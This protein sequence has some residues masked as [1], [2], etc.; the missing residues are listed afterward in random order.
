MFQHNDYTITRL[1]AAQIQVVGKNRKSHVLFAPKGDTSTPS[2]PC[3]VYG[4]CGHQ[5]AAVAFL[6][7]EVQPQAQPAPKVVQTLEERFAWG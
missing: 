6:T 3:K 2:C 4:T 1:S 5:L 7:A